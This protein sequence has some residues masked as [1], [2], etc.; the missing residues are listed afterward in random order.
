MAR[1]SMLCRCEN[2]GE[3]HFVL[4]KEFDRA[5]PPRCIGCGGRLRVGSA[6]TRL[7][8]GMDAHKEDQIKRDRKRGT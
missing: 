3:K 2:C 8:D 6:Y 4:R 1:G 5:A 7:I